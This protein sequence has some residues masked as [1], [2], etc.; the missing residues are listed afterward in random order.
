MEARGGPQRIPRPANAR[1]GSPPPWADL[2]ASKRRLTLDQVRTAVA[3]LR[4]PRRS[5][6]EGTG[7]RASAV[8]IPLYELDGEVYVVLT[9]RA[10]HLRSHQGEVSFPGGAVEPGE[11]H[12]AAALRESFEETRL[13]PGDVEVIGELDHLQ[14]VTSLSYIVPFVGALRSR[15]ELSANPDE[16]DKILHVPLSELL[17]PEVFREERWGLA[18]LDHTL[19]FFELH[20]DTVWGATAHML[21]ELLAVLTRGC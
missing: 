21:C 10:W 4:R 14:T 8:L 5:P 18:P 7:V 19:C 1:E 16:V 15:P 9:R 11:S 12:R 13:P 17:L 6:L 20:G 3:A 2:E